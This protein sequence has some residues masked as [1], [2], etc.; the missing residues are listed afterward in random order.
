MESRHATD[1][2]IP[3]R[4][5]CAIGKRGLDFGQEGVAGHHRDVQSFQNRDC[6]EVT[7]SFEDLDGGKGAVGRDVQQADLPA[8]L[9]SHEVH[10]G[11]GSFHHGA[12]AHDG[13]LGVFQSVRTHDIVTASR[14]AVELVHDG[15]Q[16]RKD[17]VVVLPLGHLALHVTVLVLHDARHQGYPRIHQV[18]NLQRRVSDELLHE[19]GFVEHDVFDG[20]RR[21][22]AVLDVHEGR[23][24]VFGGTPGDE[25]KVAC[26]LCIP[27]EK[28]SPSAIRHTIDIVMA[29][30]DVQG[31][32]CDG[33]GA[34]MKDNRK[35]FS[36]YCIEDFLHQNQSLPGREVRDAAAGDGETLAGGCRAVLGLGFDES[37][38]RAPE[39]SLSVRNRD[40]VAAAH[41]CGRG[42]RVGTRP[43]RDLRFNP[44][45][46]SSPVRGRWNTGKRRLAF[47]RDLRGLGARYSVVQ[48][49]THRKASLKYLLD[50]SHSAYQIRGAGVT[51]IPR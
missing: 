21:Q 27:A 23:L 37:Q 51:L 36:S 10:G 13:V 22:E 24:G 9:L 42:D 30:V 43:F 6:L 4:S 29:G 16:G 32:R 2:R 19:F 45:D 1:F 5:G 33:P 8:E 38:F 35:P 31:M 48:S 46:H 12:R 40:L 18:P 7:E 39:V 25:G 26:L 28:D 14:Q 41:R 50:L 49:R 15:L 20:V 34:D 17:T 3:G 44:N 11:F 47:F